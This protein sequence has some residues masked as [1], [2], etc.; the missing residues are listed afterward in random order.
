MKLGGDDSARGKM[1][2]LSLLASMPSSAAG[3]R[4]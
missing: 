2:S 1:I 4:R 3:P